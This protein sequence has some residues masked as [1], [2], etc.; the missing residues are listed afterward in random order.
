MFN[1][2]YMSYFAQIHSIME[3]LLTTCRSITTRHP[4]TKVAERT[5]RES[6]LF[7]ADNYNH[8]RLEMESIVITIIDQGM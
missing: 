1:A 4:L 3:P 7:I 5:D 8:W 2:I 6:I